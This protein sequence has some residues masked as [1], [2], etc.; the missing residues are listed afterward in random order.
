MPI[1]QTF[2]SNDGTL[3]FVSFIVPTYNLSADMLRESLESI[4]SLSL[5]ENEREIILVDD[6]SDQ[7]ALGNLSDLMNNI[8][9][10]RQPNKGAAAARN[11]GLNIAKGEYVQFV[12]GDDRLLQNGYEHCL[13][14]IR[15]QQVDLIVFRSTNKPLEKTAIFSDLETTS[16][17]D[18]LRHH[19]L[20]SCVWGYLFRRDLLGNLRFHEGITREDEEFTPQLMLR[21]EHLVATD[22]LA[23][24]YRQRQGSVMQRD[25]KRAKTR[26]LDDL[27]TV[28]DTLN[29]RLDRLPA[30]DRAALQ[31]RVDQLTMD[32]LINVITYTRSSHQLERALLRLRRRGLFPLPSKHY[33]NKYLLFAAL[34]NKRIGRKALL[35]TVPFV[36]K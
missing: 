4:I 33:N 36:I 3:P 25:D 9:Y 27:L 28:I 18:Y 35:Y 21:A 32:Y 23:Y 19:N 10:I 34:I 15:F 16:G 5:T 8:T 12:D 1:Q 24:Y 14:V 29:E 20:R 2:T 7:P 11:I 26:R 13:D 30:D 17:S 6:G 31:R 22:A